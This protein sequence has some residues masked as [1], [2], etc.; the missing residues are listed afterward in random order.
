M[1]SYSRSNI[2]LS[3]APAASKLVGL[4]SII[5]CG[6]S[7]ISSMTLSAQHDGLTKATGGSA[8]RHL[9]G[10]RSDTYGFR[11]SALVFCL[12]R[13][14]HLWGLGLLM[15]QTVFLTIRLTHPMVAIALA[16]LVLLVILGTG[17]VISAED[18]WRCNQ[19]LADWFKIFQGYGSTLLLHKCGYSLVND[20]CTNACN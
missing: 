19:L 14:F 1:L 8:Y 7:A 13:A 16:S 15:V 2:L 11:P 12:P 18:P 17:Q 20:E 10:I 9:A 6:M 3:S 5:M 4:S